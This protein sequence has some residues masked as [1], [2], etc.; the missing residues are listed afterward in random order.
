MKI[1]VTVSEYILPLIP[2]PPRP[3]K[4]AEWELAEGTTL[5]DVLNVL[6]ITDELGAFAIVNNTYWLDKNKAF[7]D[8]D[9]LLILPPI[10]GG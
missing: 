1:R 8:G 6:K 7:S 4:D 5:G 3:V 10:A 9:S 2:Q